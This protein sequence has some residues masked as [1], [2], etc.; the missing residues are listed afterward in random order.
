MIDLREEQIGDTTVL[1]V[2][3]GK[4]VLRLDQ[5]ILTKTVRNLVVRGRKRIVVDVGEI[6]SFDSSGVTDLVQCM[7]VAGRAG[8][9]FKLR[10]IPDRM[11]DVLEAAHLLAVLS[12]A[13]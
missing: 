13:D 6:P 11:R 1:R 4:G 2:R 10:N 3:W 12:E 5:G 7:A 9:E 8:A